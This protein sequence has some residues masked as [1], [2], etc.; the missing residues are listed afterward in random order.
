MD[1]KQFFESFISPPSG[2]SGYRLR[3]FESIQNIFNSIKSAL[4]KELQ[5]EFEQIEKEVLFR[6]WAFDEVCNGGVF[7]QEQE[8]SPT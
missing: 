2:D 1:K 5:K 6:A 4:N 8:N 3:S 7:P